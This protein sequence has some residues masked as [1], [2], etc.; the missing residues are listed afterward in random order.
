MTLAANLWYNY[1]F[2]NTS[3]GAWALTDPQDASNVTTVDVTTAAY[4][5]ANFDGS[6]SYGR[7]NGAAETQTDASQTNSGG[8]GAPLAA[9]LA[10]NHTFGATGHAVQFDGPAGTYDVRIAL[11]TSAAAGTMWCILLDG[12][13]SHLSSALGGSVTIQFWVASTPYTTTAYIV[14]KADKS[15]WKC[16]QAGTSGTTEPNDAGAVGG[17]FTDGGAKW[18][19]Q[20]RTALALYGGTAA[21]ASAVV[22]TTN[23][24]IACS[25]WG[26]NTD[27][28]TISGT[29]GNAFTLLKVQSQNFYLRQFGMK[30]RGYALADCTLADEFGQST[31]APTLYAGQPSGEQALKVMVSSGA[32][33]LAAFSFGGDLGAYFTPTLING[34]I[35][36]VHNGSRIPDALAGTR[37]LTITQTDVGA[38]SGSPHTTTFNCTVVSSQGRTTDSSV[39]G[40]ISTQTW[41]E[42]KTVKDV[43]ATLW[44]GYQGQAFASD[45]LV[46]DRTSWAAALNAITPNGTSWYRIRLG[47]GTYGGQYLTTIAKDFGSGGLLIEPNSG[48]DPEIS[49]AFGSLQIHRVHIRNVKLVGD[50]STPNGAYTFI[51]TDPGA[52]GIGGGGRFNRVKVENCRI[53]FMY[54]A[55]NVITDWGTKAAGC[56]EMFH[57]ESLEVV[58]CKIWGGKTV[59]PVSGVRAVR[60]SSCDYQQ[61]LGDVL[62]PCSAAKWVGGSTTGV[63]ADDNMY[64]ELS[65]VTV[66]HEVDYAGYTNGTHLDTAQ[67]YRNGQNSYRWYSGLSVA[68]GSYCI[69]LEDSP[70]SIWKAS[71]AGTAS[72]QPLGSGPTATDGTIT[73]TRQGNAILNKVYILM[74]NVTEQSEGVQASNIAR[75]FFLDS[76]NSHGVETH[77][78]AINCVQGSNSA[79]GIQSGGYGVVSAEF[80]SFIAPSRQYNST[81]NLN[82]AK[83]STDGTGITGENGYVRSRYN[84]TR[85]ASAAANPA[86]LNPASVRASAGYTSVQNE[87]LITGSDWSGTGADPNATLTGPFTKDVN[88]YWTYSQLVDDGSVTPTQFRTQM[89][90]ILAA[91]SG[92]AGIFPDQAASS[93]WPTWTQIT[94]GLG[95]T[96]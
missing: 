11:N 70:P 53:G 2:R 1:S 43:M 49:C 96:L 27:A 50:A 28:Q 76:N 61:L 89:R 78:T 73:W 88:N 63:F 12:D 6:A 55:G 8:A 36:A 74:E 60:V 91:K 59:F 39:L 86:S 72:V 85:Q 17:V 25:S 35:Y 92:M 69:S 77:V 42:R 30:L 15:I 66:W 75:Q 52:S 90:S 26:S 65:D 16:S 80:N 37:T 21:S 87:V 62:S 46:T 45:T 79:Y 22:D 83:I 40:A 41:L 57:G 51:F 47:A 84:I 31:S 71:G 94:L 18:T 48:D 24:S 64:V 93:G 23:A 32:Y 44:A 95:A 7:S 5:T 14:S 58:N 67:I 10:G 81:G 4:P 82:Q 29:Y 34:S 33:T 56:V 9:L 19:R 13:I 54:G 3:G 20:S 68:D 38:T